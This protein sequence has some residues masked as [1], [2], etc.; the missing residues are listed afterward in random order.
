M[1]EPRHI[2]VMP[3]AV[4]E[5]LAP[6]PGGVYIDAT[7]GYGGHA[8]LLA[9]AAGAG[10]RIVGLDVDPAA[11]AYTDERLRARGARYDLLRGNFGDLEQL[12]APLALPR[13]DGILF[14][15]GVS[16]PQLDLPERGFSFRETGPLD[17]RLDPDAPLTAADLINSLSERELAQVLRSY[18]DERYAERIAR[19]VVERRDAH[20]IQTTSE[21][22]ELVVRA[23]PAKRRHGRIHCA[24]RTFLALR[25]ATNR[26]LA[27]LQQGLA[28]GLAQLSV[29]GRVVV[30]AYHSGEDRIVKRVLRRH[31]G[32]PVDG[33]EAPP[34][35]IR[36]QIL[37]RRPVEPD[38][39]EVRTNPRARSAKL[40][41]AERVEFEA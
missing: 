31:S 36:V 21:L 34:A 33:D 15:L 32:R 30:L 41:A 38:P 7:V 17:F 14:D 3:D 5:H 27:S 35:D 25:I 1:H 9:D 26:E 29:G 39:E 12:L 6:R 8:V 11:L 22:A 19:A 40:R 13:V 2:P 16:S 18:G 23:Y 24:S 4:L 10:G 28:A 20:P 37:T